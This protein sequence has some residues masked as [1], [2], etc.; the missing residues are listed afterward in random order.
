M[1]AQF[2]SISEAMRFGWRTAKKHFWFFLRLIAVVLVVTYGP[3]LIAQSFDRTELPTL[4]VLLF[5]L[6]GILFWVLQLLVSVGLIQIVLTHVSGGRGHINDLFSGGRHVVNY[7]LGSLAYGLA[8]AAG[9]VLL[10]IPGIILMV[11][12]Q[13][14]QYLIVDA[15][16]GPIEAL[17]ASWDITRGSFWNLALFWLAVIGVNILGLAALG[18]GLLWSAPTAVL[19]SG[20]VYRRLSQRPHA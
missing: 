11:R 20:V 19:A 14:Y 12:L 8:V 6:A 7:F 18:I 2:F 15:R 17:K 16:M 9:F 5:F 13:F 1:G 10:V 4:A 3:A